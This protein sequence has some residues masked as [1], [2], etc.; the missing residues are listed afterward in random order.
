[1]VMESS[2]A[3]PSAPRCGRRAGHQPRRQ[4]LHELTSEAFERRGLPPGV[5]LQGH[6][7]LQP[8]FV[9]IM[10]D[11]GVPIE[12]IA[13]LVGHAGTSVTEAVYRHQLKPVITKGAHTM[14]TIFGDKPTG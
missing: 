10:S 2:V 14:N 11:Q 4:F 8:A 7:A 12:T 1:M 13:D 9:S 5:D 3:S 6:P